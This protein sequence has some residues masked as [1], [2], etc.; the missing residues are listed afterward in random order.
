MD[1]GRPDLTHARVT[2]AYTLTKR[3]LQS[4]LD[5]PMSVDDFIK[6]IQSK[7][8][9][10]IYRDQDLR[11]DGLQRI[12]KAVTDS[13]ISSLR[14]Y[15]F[16][17]NKH[18]GTTGAHYLCNFLLQ[19]PQGKSA[20]HLDLSSCNIDE[21]SAQKL[22][23]AI[24]QAG[25]LFHLDLSNNPISDEKILD[26]QKQIR[27][28]RTCKLV[29]YKKSA[30]LKALPALKP[31]EVTAADAK[32]AESKDES[33]Q[34]AELAT[35]VAQDVVP[36]VAKSLQAEAAN[37]AAQKTEPKMDDSPQAELAQKN[38]APNPEVAS[39][40]ET[41]PASSPTETKSAV[42]STGKI[43]ALMPAQKEDSLVADASASVQ[44]TARS[45]E[46]KMSEKIPTSK[47]AD[48]ISVT[49][50]A[51]AETDKDFVIVSDSDNDWENENGEADANL[52]QLPDESQL[53]D[54][55]ID[56]WCEI[57]ADGKSSSEDEP[58]PEVAPAS[59]RFG[60]R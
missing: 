35:A 29:F 1:S 36:K 39:Q 5:K 16:R 17:K 54:N 57:E 49:P 11:P 6:T 32:V 43:L 30:E 53:S 19:T 40:A 20:N 7:V 13:G 56:G 18:L 23:S 46:E 60:G 26:L 28:P 33:L 31:S 27:S 48:D 8:L 21:S 44:H 38:I 22:V 12:L 59:P 3:P 24:N 25:R 51:D 47:V 55:D 4:P 9:N 58:T 2:K 10:I 37:V 15:N 14:Y 45:S 52:E 34:I 42:S 41:S 50:D